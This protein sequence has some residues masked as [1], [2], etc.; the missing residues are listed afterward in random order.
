MISNCHW[1][2]EHSSILGRLDEE[3][4]GSLGKSIHFTD[5]LF[6]PPEGKIKA[7]K[8][9]FAE[10]LR[11]VQRGVVRGGGGGGVELVDAKQILYFSPIVF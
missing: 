11:V 7:K 1:P 9:V 6:S 3:H 10:M 4:S 5:V 8:S 2:G